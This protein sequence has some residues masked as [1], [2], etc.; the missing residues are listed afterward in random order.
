MPIRGA[1]RP[2]TPFSGLILSGA[3]PKVKMGTAQFFGK[4]GAN[5]I[6]PSFGCQ[7]EGLGYVPTPRDPMPHAF[8]LLQLL[9]IIGPGRLDLL[10]ARLDGLTFLGVEDGQ[11]FLK[12]AHMVFFLFGNM[13]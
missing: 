13:I 3:V 8:R 9:K 6:R 5:G 12:F 2:P 4:I 11:Q 10:F 7:T 1:A